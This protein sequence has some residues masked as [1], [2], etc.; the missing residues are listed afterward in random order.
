M[1]KLFGLGLVTFTL[2]AA[3]APATAGK[4][5]DSFACGTAYAVGAEDGNLLVQHR[6][7]F[8]LVTVGSDAAIRDGKGRS[9]TLGDIRPGDWIEYWPEGGKA[10]TRKISVNAQHPVDCSAPQV[11]GQNG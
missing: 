5:T 6:G 3:I 10:I 4:K 9:L 8:S 7:K 11:L 1:K 2:L